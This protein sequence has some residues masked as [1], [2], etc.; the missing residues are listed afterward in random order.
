MSALTTISFL[1]IGTA[2]TFS[3]RLRRPDASFRS[4]LNN[5]R[6]DLERPGAIWVATAVWPP[7]SDANAS[8]ASTW[9]DQ[10][11]KAGYRFLLPIYSFTQNGV[12]TGTP[13]I[14]GAGQ[15]GLSL[16]TDGWTHGVTAIAKR[17][18]FLQ[19][20]TGQLLRVQADV[21]SD[22]SGNATFTVE[23][24]LRAAP[25]D[26]SAVTVASPKGLFKLVT[27]DP[28]VTKAQAK[29]ASGFALDFEE[30]LQL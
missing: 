23:P 13:L 25:A 27:S 6:R 10:A 20:A 18:D 15:S 8:E 12:L 21:N 9:L 7:L 5:V 2:A 14:N 11:G 3:W 17:G 24:A 30:E 1:N 19:L 26:N 28:G 29:I 16:I 22:G 4:P